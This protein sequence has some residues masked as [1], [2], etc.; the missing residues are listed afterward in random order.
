M[1]KRNVQESE[2]AAD[3][4]VG[5]MRTEEEKMIAEA[6]KAAGLAGKERDAAETERFD[7]EDAAKKSSIAETQVCVT[8]VC[9]MVYP[10]RRATCCIRKDVQHGVSAKTCNCCIRKDVELV[11]IALL[12]GLVDM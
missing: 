12:T 2:D 10:Q 9:H 6:D 11:C 8:C 7:A 1:K 5:E 4:D 3:R